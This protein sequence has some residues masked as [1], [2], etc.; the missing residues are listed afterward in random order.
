MFHFMWI[1]YTEVHT[2]QTII[3]IFQRHIMEGVIR[4]GT[5]EVQKLNYCPATDLVVDLRD[6]MPWH[7][8]QKENIVE[9]I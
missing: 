7:G 2:N 9:V 8:L 3:Y 6:N 4:R 5:M 1:E